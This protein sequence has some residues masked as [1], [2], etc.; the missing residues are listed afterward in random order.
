MMACARGARSHAGLANGGASTRGGLSATGVPSDTDHSTPR[1]VKCPCPPSKTAAH[2]TDPN[3]LAG[4]RVAQS[5]SLAPAG[6]PGCRAMRRCSTLGSTQQA[7]RLPPKPSRLVA[8]GDV[9]LRLWPVRPL[10]RPRLSS[11]EG[12]ALVA[13]DGKGVSTACAHLNALGVYFR[14]LGHFDLQHAVLG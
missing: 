12:L 13:R 8:A 7:R 1:P 2:T 11:A 10:G 4:N 14:R 6:R 9:M 3:R 5:T